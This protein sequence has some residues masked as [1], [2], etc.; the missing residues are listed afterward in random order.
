MRRLL[1]A[2]RIAL[3][4]I[5]ALVLL[6]FGVAC[7][8][9]YSY[10]RE[11]ADELIAT[12]NEGQVGKLTYERVE[13][14]PF[15]AFPYISIDIKGVRFDADKHTEGDPAIYTFQDV[16]VGFDLSDL[17]RGQYTV[18]K[19]VLSKGHFYLEKHP[20]GMY[21]LMRAKQ[22]TEGDDEDTK[23]THLDLKRIEL[24]DVT[25]H[26]VN[27]GGTGNELLLDII[28]ARAY[29]SAIGD[30][31]R[32]GLESELFLHHFRSGT[33]TWFRELPF[34]L[35]CDLSIRDGMVTIHPSHFVVD[36]GRLDMQGT[37]D[38]DN[39]L[40]LDL[41]IT[42]RKKNF[43]VF[44][45]F[46]PPEVLTKLKAF[47][48]EGDIFFDGRI[49]GPIAVRSP[50]IDLRL[51]CRN[52]VFHHTAHAK[53]LR[54]VAFTGHF[55]TGDD[56][57]LDKAVLELENLYGTPEKGLMRG[58]LRVENL[59]DPRIT[60]D[61]HAR[62]QLEHLKTFYELEAIEDGAGT[63]LID[64][65]LNEYVGPDSVLHFATKMTDGVMSR[66]QFE[67]VRLKLAR[68]NRP[69]EDL[70]GRIVLDGDD[71][72]SEDLRVRIGKSDLSLDCSVSNVSALLHHT[73]AP[74]DLVLKGG[75][76]QLLL[77]ELIGLNGQ[78]PDAPWAR[79]TVMD[80]RFDLDLHT[81]VDALERARYLPGATLNFRHLEFRTAKF[82][83]AVE[84]VSGKLAVN[85][86]TLTLTAL[87]LTIGR[88]KALLNA[89]L[90][91][92][93]ALLDSTR[94]ETVHH[95]LDLRVPYLNAKELLVYDGRPF[96]HDS[97]EEEVVHDLVFRGSGSLESNTFTK[98]GFISDTHIDHLTVRVNDLPAL[99]D[100]DG[101]IITDTSGCITLHGL[102]MRMGRS[103]LHADLYL[104]HFLDGDLRNKQLEGTVRASDLDLDEISGWNTN[105]PKGEGS[106]HDAGFN[107]FALDFPVMHLT[108][109]IGRIKHHRAL[110]EDLHGV[111]H[112]NKD[113]T[114]R[115]DTLHFR[116][117]G[118]QV[119]LRGTFNGARQDSITL[120]GD[121]HLS[122]VDLDKVMY[123]LDNFGQDVLVHDNL[124]GRVSG[125]IRIDARLHTD[126]VPDLAHTTAVA[127]L[128]VTDGRI[129]RFAPLH[130]MADFMGDRDLDNVRFGELRNTFTFRAG[131]LHFPEMK[132]TSTLGYMHL[133]G[134]QSLDLQMDYTMRLPLGLVKQ[135]SWNM[136]R[137][138]LRGTGRNKDDEQELERAG[139]EI[140]THQKGPFKGYLTVNITGSP[141]N[142]QVK[143]GKS[144]KER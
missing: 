122:R 121:L 55:R 64:I 8:I 59:L 44:I 9:L 94:R 93:G 61:F 141:E 16:F 43:D 96:V 78:L 24:R 87:G 120:S 102:H 115:F 27:Q 56:G 92:V 108:A 83:F 117:A 140:V 51:G 12:I 47:K 50:L 90:Q 11:I 19:V 72:R 2:F 130:A 124:H 136:L 138:K 101:R 42:G 14:S 133:S 60:M 37:L 13:L 134:R 100:V 116:A 91:G 128:T 46:A 97:I 53:A 77:A 99:R 98:K 21:N 36:A 129:T 84:D 70:N 28:Q 82:P 139:E 25:V 114:V 112:T 29:L 109:D 23:Q 80:L 125:T 79:D 41:A 73:N 49:T 32:M 103:D 110:L 75:S 119:G 65:T 66:I 81:T 6:T 113:H 135:A 89:H 18:K 54:D 127:D 34:G 111:L 15:R 68:L 20:D 26:E 3:L 118:G 17:L 105:A 131:A 85:D 57:G 144:R 45:A 38:L 76:R 123:K 86:S 88:N 132:V 71:L 4:A 107:L 31:L 74:V 106:A 67:N 95:R 5:L 40:L 126:L 58:A 39:D 142:Y 52:T 7:Y 48:N 69:I 104:R 10:E 62:F 1:R 30:D 33:T 137:S 22:R 63:V 35:D 143:L